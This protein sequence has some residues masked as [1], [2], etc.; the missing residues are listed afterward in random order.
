M[1][2]WVL[3]ASGSA[4][5]VAPAPVA[6][7]PVAAAGLSAEEALRFQRDVAEL[8]KWPSRVV[9]T[10]G[11]REAEAYLRQQLQSLGPAVEVREHEFDVLAPVTQ[12]ATLTAPDG[13]RWE[14]HPF[15]PASVRLNTTPAEGI[16]G[17]VVYIGRGR[18]NEFSAGAVAGQIA[19]I[20][21]EA[22]EG[23]SNAFYFGARALLILGA[24]DTNNQHLRSHDLM[25]PVH[26]PRFYVPPGELA[27]RIRAGRWEDVAGSADAAAKGGGEL[28]L[29]SDVRWQRTRVR[30]FYAY[31]AP[32][33][34]D[35]EEVR[36]LVGQLGEA[37]ASADEAEARLIQLGPATEPVLQRLRESA[38]AAVQTRIDRVLTRVPR[39][40]LLLTAAY[41][42][43]SLV[44]DLG[45][46]ASQAVQPA[47]LLGMLREL[48]ERPPRRPVVAA[49]LGA[50]G[51]EFQATRQMFMALADGP[52]VWQRRI[53]SE[54]D[55]RLATALTHLK[56]LQ[57]L[58]DDPSQLDA[59]GESDIADRVVK[60]IE[61]DQSQVQDRLFRLRL[62]EQPTAES[63]AELLEL[64]KHQ[65]RLSAVRAAFLRRPGDLR[66]ELGE[67]G[68]EYVR[69]TIWRL[70]GTPGGVSATP[71]D[72]ALS[73]DGTPMAELVRPLPTEG[74]I[75]QLE[76][77]RA[78]LEFRA[79]TYR[80]L[81]GRTRT[82]PNPTGRANNSRAVE[83]QI[84]VDLTGEGIR[85][86]PMS[87]GAF[88]DVSNMTQ[89][90][91]YRDW[92]SRLETQW[93][94]LQP[95]GVAGGA[96]GGQDDAARSER[97]RRA[98]W[99]GAHRAVID[100]EP[101]AGTRSIR[102]WLAGPVAIGSEMCQAWGVP[103]FTL[104]TLDDMRLRRDTP[105][106]TFE[107]LN[108][109][110]LLRQYAALR[111]LVLRAWE[112]T[113]FRGPVENPYQ[114]ESFE[115]QVVS[116]APGRPV[117]DLPREGFLVTRYQTN[118]VGSR[119][120]AVSWAMGYVVGQRRNEV[121]E[122]DA[123]GMYF[124]EGLPRLGINDRQQFLVLVY[125]L[126]ADGSVIATSDFGRQAG[127]IRPY[128]DIRSTV[129][130]LRSVPFKCA[131]VS[132]VGL[133]DPRFLQDLGDAVVLDARRNA[134]PQRYSR[135]IFRQM[136]SMFVEPDVRS[137][138]LLRYGRVGNRLVLLNMD[139]RP[140]RGA[141]AAGG[142]MAVSAARGFDRNQLRDIGPLNV[143]T[144][145]DFYRLNAIRLEGYRRAGVS[146]GLLDDLQR[147]TL[148]QLELARQSYEMTSAVSLQG[149][150]SAEPGAG[151]AEALTRWAN[152]AWA[153]Q[154]RVYSAAADMANDVIRAAI[155][156]LLL[157]V[158]FAFCMERLLVAS[159]NVYRQI[160]G[161][162]AIFLVMM[163]ALWSF[164]P[165]F[166]ISS[167]PL[168][169]V[170]AFAIITMSA[171]VIFVIYS[172]FDAELKRI[173]SG[174][175][176]A[177]TASLARA[178]VLMS[179]VLLGIAN[180]RKRKFRTALTA[181]TI[182]LITFAVLAFTS[183]SRLLDTTTLATGEPTRYPGLMLRQRG[184]RPM[185][186]AVLENLRAT[187]GER[188]IIQRWWNVN[189]GDPRDQV[190]IVAGDGSERPRLFAAAALLGLSPGEN[191]VSRIERVLG[192]EAYARLER[193]ERDI[194]FLPQGA[195]RRLEVQPG[196]TVRVGGIALTVAG[197][198]DP[199]QFD[200]E[201][202]SLSGEPLAPLRYAQGALDASGRSLADT[203]VE[204]LDL[205]ANSGAAELQTV[206]EHLSASQFAI[207]PAELSRILPN[208]SLRT[209][210]VRLAD[211]DEVR[212]VGDEVARRFA[213][214]LFAGY[215]DGVRMLAAGNLTSV[216]GAGQVAI[217]LAIAGLI[218]FNTMM[219]SIAERKR[220]IHVYTSLGLAPLHVG[221]LFVAEA[222]TYGLIGAV[223]GYII[224]QGVGTVL[225]NLGW[226]GG[227]TLNYSG[228]SAMLTL[229]LILVVVLLSALV[230][231]R[232]A[233][234]IAA[235]SIERNWRVPLPKGDQITADLP[236]TI[237]KTA[238]MG[239][240][241]YLAEFF[242][243]HREGS[244][245]KFS[246][247]KVE[248]FSIPDA[249]GRESRGLKTVVWLT[250]F[251]LGVRQHLMLLI[252]PGEFEDIYEVQVVLQRLSGDDSSWYRMNRTFLTE[253][254][255]Q[256]LQW[257]SLTPQRMLE[258]IEESRKLFEKPVDKVVEVVPGDVVR[259]G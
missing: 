152:G 201:V 20:E 21:A 255:K 72:L 251:D 16:R 79:E 162:I 156:L 155:F 145:Q 158:P 245:G 65:I 259:L 75:R 212:R 151:T 123:E 57:E 76:R 193:G 228:T 218:I 164:H 43:T 111:T 168:I 100:F 90:Q 149:Q 141:Q 110:S 7:A 47:V 78:E 89:I 200:R 128:A 217:P 190:H 85:F 81:A 174:R 254:R 49:F 163:L 215:D 246:A 71:A 93:E 120:P 2:L 185:P 204:S 161:V 105:T 104:M 36:R 248:V 169:I 208:G 88:Q 191:T 63:K 210:T 87:Q 147:H 132:L 53:A 126:A 46:G 24:P 113:S 221:A 144:A 96:A 42:A 17:R 10:P 14:V 235:P 131:E 232:L 256:F 69:R 177:Q 170:L 77:R 12:S 153:N 26:L 135:L 122:T 9:G 154:T 225:M 219:G 230:P 224:G 37:R 92:F 138:L 237:N 247:G 51:I 15:W 187:L 197:V 148:E 114:R 8:S 74:L 226:L 22:P 250:P 242:D 52:D 13:R 199:E 18:G 220:E 179:A 160:A 227:V 198:Y 157:C 172:K 134:D 55:T 236:F 194:I 116:L 173:R 207:V 97:Q 195:A 206:Y 45:P 196:D 181:I 101:L 121:R 233:S 112:D 119:T 124:F 103:G 175:G 115:G 166:K 223:F 118:S 127:D 28:V 216:S 238:A 38:P 61:T 66:G 107:T 240:V 5:P 253:L 117:P 176:T 32:G 234:Q 108:F 213:V 140:G 3:V 56:R 243:A 40:A 33:P 50:D 68:R 58:L 59:V 84:A 27:D 73:T 4:A 136:L 109:A 146:S 182:V 239:A 186:P 41:D 249:N 252:H 1:L 6:V 91:D 205:D 99:F 244:I 83:M 203:A 202:V 54:V 106:D 139:E 44:P 19:A 209:V 34:V 183:S 214:A 133:Y 192:S 86:G 129:P 35:E 48:V 241:A 31:V 180:M 62:M 82:N 25:I 184:F 229:G 95:G 64:E 159:P 39:G 188:P 143:Q 150:G 178:S 211:E 222:L 60:I 171:V 11:H 80:W 98:G 70:A 258:Y 125:R 137:F 29:R 23:W 165:A 130:T 167:S 257:R 30:N 94:S 67:L 142:D 102:A 189:A 231:A